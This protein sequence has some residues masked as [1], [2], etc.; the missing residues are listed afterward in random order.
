MSRFKNLLAMGGSGSQGLTESLFRD[1]KGFTPAKPGELSHPRTVPV[2]PTPRTFSIVE[3]GV[4][5]EKAATEEALAKATTEAYKAIG[6]IEK[7]DEARIAAHYGYAETVA[8]V[9]LAVKETHAKYAN[10]LQAQRS[11]YA[12]LSKSHMDALQAAEASVAVVQARVQAALDG[13]RRVMG[14]HR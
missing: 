11:Q 9:N 7:A 5:Q 4:L 10:A 2:I 3:A 14:G 1:P 13:H 12:A 6:K 8:G